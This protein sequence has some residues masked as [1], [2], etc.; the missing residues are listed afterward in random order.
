MAALKNSVKLPD[1]PPHLKASGR[2]W[3]VQVVAKYAFESHEL[4]LVTAAAEMLDRA[5]AAR[6]LVELEGLVVQ[7]RFGQIAAHPAAALERQALNSFR[8][9]A[10]EL[11]LDSPVPDSRPPLPKGY[12]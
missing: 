5:A 1:S 12:R 7:D 2:A 6:E 3:F 8:L 4:A 9:L 11:A 10:R